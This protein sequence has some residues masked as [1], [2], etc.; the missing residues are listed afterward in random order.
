MNNDKVFQ[1]DFGKAYGLLLDKATRKGRTKAE[2]DEVVCWLTGYSPEQL[3]AA[4]SATSA[5]GTFSVTR[6]S[7]TRTGR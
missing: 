5:T 6:P 7:P 3:E 1:M 2:V 4:R